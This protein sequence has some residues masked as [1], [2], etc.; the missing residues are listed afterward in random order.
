MPSKGKVN[1]SGAA[2][3][4]WK[5]WASTASPPQ[6]RMAA[7]ASSGSG[8]AGQAGSGLVKKR[9]VM[10][11]ARV[12]TSH[13][14]M[15]TTPSSRSGTGVQRLWSVT[16]TASSPARRAARAISSREERPSAEALVWTWRSAR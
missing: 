16:A 8:G 7:T 13:P 1:F 5:G 4:R 3:G 14:G 10:W 12:E 9:A 2:P 11:P 15:K 6:S